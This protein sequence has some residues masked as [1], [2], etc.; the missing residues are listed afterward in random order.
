MPEA[1]KYPVV[2]QTIEGK[3]LAIDAR[4]DTVKVGL[5]IGRVEKKYYVQTLKDAK[6]ELFEMLLDKDISEM[7]RVNIKNML[8]Q[9]HARAEEAKKRTFWKTAAQTTLGFLTLSAIAIGTQL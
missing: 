4:V 9:Y 2:V 1:N 5:E 7:Q 8:T 6:T 3:L